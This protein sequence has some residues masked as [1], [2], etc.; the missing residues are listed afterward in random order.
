MDDTPVSGPVVQSRALGDTSSIIRNVSGQLQDVTLTTYGVPVTP[1]EAG[2]YGYS[3]TR[4]A[5][6]L[7]GGIAEGPWTIGERR[8]IVLAVTPFEKVDPR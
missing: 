2:G 3:I 6:T 8:V 5:F 7:E 4:E 1:P